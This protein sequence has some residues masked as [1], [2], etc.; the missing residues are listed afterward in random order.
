[1]RLPVA[2]LL[3]W[4]WRINSHVAVSQSSSD[5]HSRMNGN[6]G[7]YCGERIPIERVL[8][9]LESEGR[10]HGWTVQE[11]A[12][13]GKLPVWMFSRAAK[14][15]EAQPKRV[16]LSAGIHG[17][18]PAGPMAI[19]R[20]L[21]EN[22]WPPDANITLFPC[23]NPTGFLHN[24]REGPG[25]VDLNRDYLN[26]KT[27]L[28]K[29]LLNWLQAQEDYDLALC[30]HEDWEADGFYLYELCAR[31]EES[32]ATAVMKAVARDCPVLRATEA[33]GWTAVGGIV[34]PDVN[35]DEREE[36]PEAVYLFQRMTDL[37][38]TFEAPS[39]YPLPLR[40]NALVQAVSASLKA[41]R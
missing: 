15:P 32:V 8:A 37:C 2:A 30:I 26:P 24:R 41:C 39:D 1:M 34:R 25:G 33:D 35:P 22:H 16:F 5:Q 13:A 28:V 3:N 14:L 19:L 11:F 23:L 40:V 12:R 17:D 7:G 38:Y 27:G 6:H 10:R 9:D 21:R 4:Q 31:P 29:Q 20:M 18:E 36:W